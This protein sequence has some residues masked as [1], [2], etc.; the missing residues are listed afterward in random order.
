MISPAVP[1]V[2]A[3]NVGTATLKAAL[4]DADAPRPAAQVG[5]H[6]TRDAENAVAQVRRAFEACVAPA[7]VA[8]RI[9]HGGRDHTAAVR[10]D[11]AVEQALEALVPLAP[12]HNAAALQVLRSARRAWPGVPQVAVFDTAFHAGMPERAARYAVPAAWEQAGLRRYGFHGLSHQHVMEATAARL[13]RPAAELRIVSCH[14]GSGASVCAIER[15]ASID[16]S[17]GLTPLEGLIMAT[18]SGDLDPGAA[19]Y[20]ARTLGLTLPEIE[21]ALYRDSGLK[22]LT[23]LDGDMRAIE[24][25]AQAGDAAACFALEAYAY[26]IL[27]YVGAYAAAMGG[28]DAL[29][30]TGGVGENAPGVRQRVLERLGFLGAALDDSANATPAF[31]DDGVAGVHAAKSLPVLVVRAREEWLVARQARALLSGLKTERRQR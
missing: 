14:L 28:C 25:A 7:V 23:G 15:G 21:S 24:A 11:D 29:V 17:M 9:V 16:T 20:V 1:V 31:D 27:K 30:F 5:F 22:A 3:L 2:L 8:H 26:R 19:G 4:F 13:G 18:R 10:V 6:A 12:L